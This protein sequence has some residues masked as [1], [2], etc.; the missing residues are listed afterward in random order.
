MKARRDI[1]SIPARSAADTWQ[2]VIDLITGDGS[3]HVDDLRAVAGIAAS[4]IT[5]EHPTNDPI[6]VVGVGLRVVI[7][8]AYG[9]NAVVGTENVDELQRNPTA[10]DWQVLLPCNE[11][12]LPWTSKALAKHT[13]RVQVYDVAEPSPL[14]ESADDSASAGLRIAADW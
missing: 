9:E 7:Y 14:E 4:I 13:T 1:N 10:G 5:D 3:M 6:I 2:K 12:N 8:C 11:T